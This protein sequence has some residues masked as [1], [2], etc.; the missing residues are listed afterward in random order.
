MS[1][2]SNLK[3]HFDK[4]SESQS[5][6]QTQSQTQY[7]NPVPMPVPMSMSMPPPYLMN[8][9]APPP[10]IEEDDEEAEEDYD[11]DDE[12]DIDGINNVDNVSNKNATTTMS[13]TTPCYSEALAYQRATR[14]NASVT[15][16]KPTILN[17]SLRRRNVNTG[18]REIELNDRTT[19]V[20]QPTILTK[21][22]SVQFMPSPK[23]ENY[24]QD[25]VDED[26]DED[27]NDDDNDNSSDDDDRRNRPRHFITRS[28]HRSNP[29]KKIVFNGTFP[30]DDPYSSRF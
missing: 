1:K 16:V 11:D 28:N 12:D 19:N 6:S 3:S 27:G 18:N 5:L 23:Y 20:E 30:I 13:C 25:D 2:A 8:Q 10:P 7:T 15:S 9:S 21:V 24:D 22:K 29:L 17:E 26:D 4:T 14:V